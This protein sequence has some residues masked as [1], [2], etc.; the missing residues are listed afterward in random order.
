MRICRRCLEPKPESEFGVNRFFKDGKAIY[1]K[2]CN[3]LHTARMRARS[4]E[5]L[6]TT[7][8]RVSFSALGFK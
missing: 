4:V 7:K 5:L 3:K 6:R 1:C 8:V 2:Q